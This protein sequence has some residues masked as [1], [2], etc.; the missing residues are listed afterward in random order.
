[1]IKV[2]VFQ[3]V[4]LPIWSFIETIS[5]VSCYWGGGGGGGSNPILVQ[6]DQIFGKM[7]MY[8]N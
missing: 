1:M 2:L 4:E 8:K 5:C 6:D 7:D 3:G